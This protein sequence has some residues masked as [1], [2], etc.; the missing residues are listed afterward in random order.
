MKAVTLYRVASVLLVLFAAGHTFGFLKF[1]A[2]TPE[3]RAVFE[4]MNSVYFQAG[5]SSFSYGGFY[6]GFG[7]Y[8]TLYL[9]FAAFLAWHLGTMVRNSP[10]AIG[11][12]GWVFC[13]VQV[14]SL[15]LSWKYFSAPPAVF[16]AVIAICLGLASWLVMAK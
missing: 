11:A 3:G 2:P 1:K 16:S 10:S 6:Q 12:L 8:T 13:A 9:L 5:G 15:I 4:S 7:L 14:V